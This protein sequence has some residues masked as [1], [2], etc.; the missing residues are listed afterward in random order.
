MQADIFQINIVL[1]WSSCVESFFFF[2]FMETFVNLLTIALILVFSVMLLSFSVY[3]FHCHFHSAS[4]SV[5]LYLPYVI[6]SL[7]LSF[8]IFSKDLG[9]SSSQFVK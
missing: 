4:P 3:L 2:S 7:F 5:C 9:T 8:F 6:L 1:C